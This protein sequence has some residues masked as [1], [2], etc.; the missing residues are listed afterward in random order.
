MI[1]LIR[2]YLQYFH[3][4]F[5]IHSSL[6]IFKFTNK[7]KEFYLLNKNKSQILKINFKLPSY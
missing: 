5:D 7:R 4:E 6:L 1:L 2:R 3:L